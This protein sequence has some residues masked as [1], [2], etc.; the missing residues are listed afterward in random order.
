[1]ILNQEIFYS[2]ISEYRDALEDLQKKYKKKVYLSYNAEFHHHD[3]KIMSL[4][5]K[6][7]IISTLNTY[8]D[9]N[10]VLF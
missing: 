5:T 9:E 3:I 2:M 4:Q 1:V 8:D 7:E 6:A 10:E